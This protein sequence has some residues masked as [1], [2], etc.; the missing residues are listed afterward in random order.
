MISAPTAINGHISFIRL[1]T[2]PDYH[3]HGPQQGFEHIWLRPPLT[4]LLDAGIYRVKATLEIPDT[5]FRKVKATAAQRGQTIEQFVV[6]AM[7]E[8]LRKEHSVQN[9]NKPAWIDYFGAFGKTASM[10]A[11]T[12][13]IQRLID[14]E[15]EN[16][17]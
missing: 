13:R 17:A 7:Q 16:L 1:A 15:F 11:E 9:R 2:H 8:E 12:R 5:L 14:D 4:V 10:R 3:R 6:E